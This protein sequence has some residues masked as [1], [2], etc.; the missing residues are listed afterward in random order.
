MRDTKQEIAVIAAV[1]N[2][3][4][5]KAFSCLAHLLVLLGID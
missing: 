1:C 2:V 5:F 3:C 4:F